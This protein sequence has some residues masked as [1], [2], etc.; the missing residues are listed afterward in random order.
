MK[1]IEQDKGKE[2]PFL[3]E[4][5]AV[6]ESLFSVKTKANT[7]TGEE[8]PGLFD[9]VTSAFGAPGGDL[10]N[11]I[12]AAKGTNKQKARWMAKMTPVLNISDTI[13]DELEDFYLEMIEAVN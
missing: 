9:A 8:G 11:F 3:G 4:L 13:R 1:K 10:A 7:V 2:S 12:E 6:A 5:I